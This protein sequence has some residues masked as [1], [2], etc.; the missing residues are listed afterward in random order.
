VTLSSPTSGPDRDVTAAVPTIVDDDAR[1]PS[2]HQTAKPEGNTR[3][4]RRLHG[5][6]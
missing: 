3:P 5:R 4:R 2:H 1:R 6:R